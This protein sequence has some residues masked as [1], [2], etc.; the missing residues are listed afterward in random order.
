MSSPMSEARAASIQ[1]QCRLSKSYYSL[2]ALLYSTSSLPSHQKGQT[3]PEEKPQL[4][5]YTPREVLAS[6][7]SR[8]TA[9]G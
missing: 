2:V 9:L 1:R 4:S 8:A 5:E 6:I 3:S 7:H